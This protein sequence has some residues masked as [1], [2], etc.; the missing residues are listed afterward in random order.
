MLCIFHCG[1]TVR[2]GGIP[3]FGKLKKSEKGQSIVEFALVLPLLLTLLCGVIDFG[4]IYSNQYRVENASYAGARYAS[5]Y[6]S[7]YDESTMNQLIKKVETRAK[8]DL[9]NGGEGATISVSV[10]SDKINVTVEYPVKNLTFVAQTF[11]G[12]YYKATSTSVTSI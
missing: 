6:I 9:W 7:D 2:K 1:Y 5:L 3:L 4:W 10:D 11:F 12:K 8:E